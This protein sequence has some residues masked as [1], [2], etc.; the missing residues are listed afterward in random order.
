MAEAQ[1]GTTEDQGST[2][3]EI[4]ETPSTMPS[5][6]DSITTEAESLLAQL[7]APR[8]SDLTEPRKIRQNVGTQ[9]RKS[10][11]SCNTDPAS[12]GPA[13]RMR[14]FPNE[15]FTVSAGNLFCSAC[16]DEVSLKIST[17][18]SHIKSNKHQCGQEAV[19]RREAWE[20][21]IVDAPEDYNKQ[22]HPAGETLPK[23]QRVF[24]VK[25]V[26]SFLRVGT[27]LNKL[28][29]FRELLEEHAYK[30]ADNCGM[31]DLIPF[32]MTDKVK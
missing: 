20:R 29:Y 10:K 2:D 4:V 9:T 27:P 32:V 11:P 25:V 21:D 14:E 30:L 17:I 6:S 31:Y 1:D 7:R 28:Q 13:K 19:A 18:R 12:I 15:P 3:M 23:A 16:R 5:R 26:K 22:A 24:R 8:K